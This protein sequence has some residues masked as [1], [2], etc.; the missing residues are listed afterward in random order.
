MKKKTKL[1]K[2]PTWDEIGQA[3]GMKMEKCK[4]EDCMPWKM[5]MKEGMKCHGC[6]GAIYGLG[7][8]GALIYYITTAT[9]ITA[10]VI[11]FFKAI[12]WPAFIV[13]GLLK[14]LGL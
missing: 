10:G 9:S 7:F 8:I 2:E 14:S 3:I 5:R 6:G 12:F 4:D 1:D 11:G 13:F